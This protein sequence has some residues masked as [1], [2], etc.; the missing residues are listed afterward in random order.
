MRENKKLKVAIV[1]YGY[2]GPNLARNF[3]YSDQFELI[4]I[5]DLSESLLIKAAINHPNVKTLTSFEEVLN[6]HNLEAVV[7]STPPSSHFMLGMKALERNK[8]VLI[9]K[10]LAQTSKECL[11]LMRE[12]RS[13]NL[14]LMVDHTFTYTGAV[15]KIRELAKSSLGELLY[16]DS[17]RINLGLFQRDIN[18]MWD[19]AVHDLSILDSL[20]GF[21]PKSVSATGLAHV[22]GYPTNTAYLTLFYEEPFIAHINCSWMAPVKIRRTL[23]GGSSKMIVYD[24]LE[25]TEKIKVYDKGIS[26]NPTDE[27]KY[28]MCVDYRTADV[29]SPKVDG[30]EALALLVEEFAGCILTNRKPASDATSGLRVVSILE[31]ADISLSKCGTPVEVQSC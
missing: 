15:M 16:Y 8:H 10:P 7:I 20:T 29:Y 22:D 17:V 1:G 28:D 25:P 4:C 3:E 26:L 9:E 2:W 27:E 5:C 30:T 12:A 21:L 13:R 23:L 31:A 11:L 24:D 6:L 18:V 14:V 19:L